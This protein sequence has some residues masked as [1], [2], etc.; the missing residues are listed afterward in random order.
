MQ[1]KFKK[2][3]L[4]LL[5]FLPIFYL[6]FGASA[7]QKT[8][9]IKTG[10]EVHFHT[11]PSFFGRFIKPKSYSTPGEFHESIQCFLRELSYDVHVL[12]FDEEDLVLKKGEKYQPDMSG[13]TSSA[14]ISPDIPLEEIPNTSGIHE[15]IINDHDVV[16]KKTISV[17][18][19]ENESL[20]I[21][22]GEK[23]SLDFG[24]SGKWSV[25]GDSLT[26]DD[27]GNIETIKEGKS[28]VSFSSGTKSVSIEINVVAM[29]KLYW[30]TPG[31]SFELPDKDGKFTAGDLITVKGNKITAVKCGK[32]NYQYKLGDIVFEGILL[33]TDLPKEKAMLKGTE[34]L[35][36][37]VSLS[38]SDSDIAEIKDGRIIARE[39]GSCEITGEYQ[40]EKRVCKLTVFSIDPKKIIGNTGQ[41]FDL[42]AIKGM[43]FSSEDK[44]IVK[45]ED[46]KAILVGGGSS[47]IH[48]QYQGQEGDIPVYVSSYENG[49]ATGKVIKTGEDGIVHRM[50]VWCQHAR[51]YDK[52]NTFLAGNGCSLC[53]LTCILNGYAKGYES[54]SPPEVMDSVEKDVIG[55][56]AWNAHHHN[57]HDGRAMPMTLYGIN[58]CMNVAGVHTEYIASFNREDMKTD[59]LNH[60]STGQPVVIEVNKTNQVSGK[61]D[62]YWSGSVHTVVLAGIDGENVIVADP[63][64]ISR[65]SGRGRIK[66]TTLDF[67]SQYM[68]SCSS[69][70]DD[71]YWSGKG[72]GGGYIKVFSR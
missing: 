24:V 32:E 7:G 11:R 28:V 2:R 15:L 46:N 51:N 14:K 8:Y 30:L 10:E 31:E 44:N 21:K 65:G 66:E 33:V 45:A 56:S 9:Y 36:K 20:Y 17:I 61:T 22:K 4:I 69:E 49:D 39:N 29:K 54:K 27:K 60:L 62:Y 18:G 59:I 68:W 38:S 57:G 43:N 41:V 48:Y 55:E 53:S 6:L 19:F 58:S 64:N 67:I 16:F 5:A 47:N 1:K 34:F 12:E 40:G 42:P 13:L 25:K 50:T 26:V 23:K 71:F 35:I 3:Y 52:Y 72:T 37:E 63:A 70:P